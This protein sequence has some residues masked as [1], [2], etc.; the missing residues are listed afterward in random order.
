MS[1][2][3]S[4]PPNSKS[5]R[6]A[7]E[8]PY[9]VSRRTLISAIALLLIGEEGTAEDRNR[10]VCQARAR[11]VRARIPRGL[12]PA[13]RQEIA[14]AGAESPGTILIDANARRLYLVL[15]ANRALAYQ[16][17]VGRDGFGWTGAVRV[18][19]KAEW[20]SWRPPAEMRKRDPQLPEHVPPGPLN[21]LGARAIYLHKNGAD[22][23]YRIHGTNETE[24]IGRNSSSGCFRLSNTDIIDLYDRVRIG[25]TVVVY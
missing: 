19:A 7:G 14:Y 12:G 21:P 11:R 16:I 5:P 9:G 25:A 13:S 18:G 3:G 22:T 17:G 15:G 24:S 4:L 20:P 8:R 2:S 10:I 1:A 6:S 23:L